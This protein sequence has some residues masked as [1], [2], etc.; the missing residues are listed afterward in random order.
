MLTFAVRP[1]G[2]VPSEGDKVLRHRTA[3]AAFYLAYGAGG[4]QGPIS[5]AT[6]SVAVELLATRGDSLIA[7]LAAAIVWA[8][9]R[10]VQAV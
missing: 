3:L 6:I 2:G 5:K 7:T 10:L 4:D 8:L 1:R 9:G